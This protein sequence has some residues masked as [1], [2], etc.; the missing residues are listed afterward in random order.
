MLVDNE[1]SKVA[2]TN[3]V[4]SRYCCCKVVTFNDIDAKKKK[5][6]VGPLMDDAKFNRIDIVRVLLNVNK[7]NDRGRTSDQ[8]GELLFIYL[9]HSF[10]CFSIRLLVNFIFNDSI[11]LSIYSF[12]CSH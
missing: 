8:Q 12:S 11:L 2:H 6:Q 4:T 1:G 3:I 10:I 7:T 9:V 5:I